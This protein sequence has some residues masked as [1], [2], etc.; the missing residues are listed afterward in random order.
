MQKEFRLIGQL[1]LLILIQNINNLT[2]IFTEYNEKS[3]EIKNNF[4]KKFYIWNIIYIM[5]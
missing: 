1:F 5:H 4:F 2:I 3:V